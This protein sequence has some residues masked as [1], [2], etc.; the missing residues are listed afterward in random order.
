MSS[1]LAH[2][3]GAVRDLPVPMWLFYYGSGIALI[4]S[5]AA[6]GALWRKPVL[7]RA[8]PRPA[9][10]AL[11][12]VV[13][14]PELRVLLG[15]VSL[16]LLALV[17]A[18]ALLGR[19]SIATNIAPT[20][21]YVIFWVGLVPVVVLFGN[22]WPALNPWNAAARAVGWVASRV[23]PPWRPP[24]RYPE[25]PGR[26][27]AAVLLLAFVTLEL[28]YPDSAAPR[29][30]ALAIALYTW[31][32][33]LGMA[34]FGREQWLRHGEAFS[35]YFGLL[36]LL[37]PFTVRDGRLA[38]RVP[39]SGIARRDA[40]PGTVA[41]V[42]I[43]LGS[44]AFDGLSSTRPWQ[45]RLF[46]IEAALALDNPGLADLALMGFNLLGLLGSVALV[47]LI[48]LV[49]VEG[50][51]LAAKGE[52]HLADEFV[53]SLVPIALAYAIAHYLT[54]LLI[55]G[56]AIWRLIS[57]PFGYGWNLFGTAGYEI[58][59]EVLSPN[60]IWY[61]QVGALVLGHVAA[62]VVAHDRAV[63]LFGS[64]AAALR[65]QYA[66]LVLMIAYT[67][68]GLWSLSTA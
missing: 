8:E 47:A 59:L 52:R 26:W 17:F 13:L 3:I 51:R 60:A 23:A 34:V 21:V 42:A 36:S 44:V 45:E 28:A 55:Q 67:V 14:G 20:F 10:A 5:F 64:A 38:L 30:L 32:T 68:G 54:L 11:S 31:I 2:G 9:G 1:L 12:R 18:A 62:L 35:V 46:S 48:F 33:W 25:R 41:F 24:A 58:D 39:L 53:L 65:T 22:V 57:D 61:L 16:G 4:V 19:E 50:A 56:Q 40:T 29:T 27:P 37:S 66:M 63:A 43:M 15:A 49:A 6:L 7:E